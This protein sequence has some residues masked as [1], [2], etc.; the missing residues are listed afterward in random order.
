MQS[1]FSK[2]AAWVSSECGEERR[3]VGLCETLRHSANKSPKAHTSG[4]RFPAGAGAE[5]R[6]CCGGLIQGTFLKA[7]RARLQRGQQRVKGWWPWPTLEVWGAIPQEQWQPPWCQERSRPTVSEEC[8]LW[9]LEFFFDLRNLE[10]PNLT[11][12]GCT[13][14][15]KGLKQCVIK[16]LLWLPMRGIS[17]CKVAVTERV[18]VAHRNLGR[19]MPR[20]PLTR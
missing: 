5:C 16:Q 3:G 10:P 6:S 7:L 17:F 19:Q 20:L 12:F 13:A 1:P 9:Q 8:C 15:G 11:M 4:L 14:Q 18:T 2:R